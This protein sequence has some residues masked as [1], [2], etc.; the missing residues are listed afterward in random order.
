MPRYVVFSFV[1]T[2][3]HDAA[4]VALVEGVNEAGRITPG[5]CEDFVRHHVYH[6]TTFV[7]ECVFL[8]TAQ[9]QDD[10]RG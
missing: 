5:S 1:G 8:K 7:L 2:Q 4:D 9:Y 6:V 3:R 10:S